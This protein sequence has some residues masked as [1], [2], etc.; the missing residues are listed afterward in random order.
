LG[1]HTV[2]S[3]SSAPSAVL[4]TAVRAAV[5]G[6][7]IAGAGGFIAC[8]SW[9]SQSHAIA[10]GCA[11]AWAATSASLAWLFWARG[12][13]MKTFWWAFG[14][15]MALRAGAL[16]GLAAWGFGREGVALEGLLLP[17]V[18]SVLILLLTLELR[19]LRIR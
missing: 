11:T 18:F 8:R 10:V 6:A 13:D 1:F 16:G 12:R 14:G 19:H 4:K 5:E 3:D 17:Y 7:V 9:P 15:G 2:S